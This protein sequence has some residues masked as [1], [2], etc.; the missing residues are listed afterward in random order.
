MTELTAEEQL[1]HMQAQQS[2][3]M[4]QH[5]KEVGE[6]IELG[7]NSY[8][9]KDFDEASQVVA[10]VL[11]EKAVNLMALVRGFDHPAEIVMHLA[12]NEQR[13]KDFAKLRP[14]QQGTELFRIEAQMSPFGQ[15]RS[16]ADP[17]WKDPEIRKGRVSDGEWSQNGGA[18]LSDAQWHREYDR[19]MAD[20]GGSRR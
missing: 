13:L 19:R 10:D 16:G 15:V 1:R 12:G 11:G 20:K 9:K 6:I 8:G 18:N 7:Q 17:A 2:M 4:A 14:E 3:G 5:H